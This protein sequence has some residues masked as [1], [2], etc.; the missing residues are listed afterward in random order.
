VELPPPGLEPL[1]LHALKEAGAREV[2]RESEGVQAIFQVVTEAPPRGKHSDHGGSAGRPG[3]TNRDSS[4]GEAEPLTEDPS[5]P[6][7]R[8]QAERRL[9]RSVEARA[10][11]AFPH[12]PP[13]LDWRPFDGVAWLAGRGEKTTSLPGHPPL[14][15]QA[16]VAFGDGEHPTTRRCLEVLARRVQPGDRVVDVGA[17]SGIL[18]VAAARLG[19]GK[20]LAV[21]MDPAG[22]PEI[23]ANAALNGVADR[24]E[25]RLHRATPEAPGFGGEW[26][27]IVANLEGP[28]LRPLLPALVRRLAPGGWLLVSGLLAPEAEALLSAEEIAGPHEGRR[29]PAEGYRGPDGGH[30]DPVAGGPPPPPPTPFE[31]H[32]DGGWITLL[33]EGPAHPGGR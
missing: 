25:A 16:G 26:N 2:R 30:M 4:H 15:I 18:S 21:E 8:S 33:L 19:A 9:R 6:A 5:G 32:D 11:V 12:H 1:L 31:H 27:G 24:V 10:R 13:H 29:A 22:R 23:E 14:R 3:R 20:V 17:G 7:S 28:I